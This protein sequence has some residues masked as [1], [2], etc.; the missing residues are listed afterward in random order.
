MATHLGL[1]DR[2]PRTVYRREG[3][4]LRPHLHDA[5]VRRADGV[6]LQPGDEQVHSAKR[7][8]V[9]REYVATRITASETKAH[10]FSI[11]ISNQTQYDYDFNSDSVM[12]EIKKKRN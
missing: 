9:V 1:Q 12:D 2:E 7:R 4:P 10:N 11:S 5:R 8:E 6:F 3:Q